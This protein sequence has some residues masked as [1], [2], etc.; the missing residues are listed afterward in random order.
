MWISFL[1]LFT[2]SPALFALHLHPS[3]SFLT[4][5]TSSLQTPLRLNPKF[6]I[7]H[8]KFS[9]RRHLDP[10]LPLLIASSFPYLVVCLAFRIPATDYLGRATTRKVQYNPIHPFYFKDGFTDEFSLTKCGFRSNSPLIF[11]R[12][13]LHFHFHLGTKGLYNSSLVSN[14]N[15]ICFVASCSLFLQVYVKDVQ[16]QRVEI[17]SV[18]LWCRCWG[19]GMNWNEKKN[20]VEMEAL[21]YFT[22]WLPKIFGM[23]GGRTFMNLAGSIYLLSLYPFHFISS[24]NISPLPRTEP[25]LQRS[26]LILFSKFTLDWWVY[27]LWWWWY[28]VVSCFELH[29]L[30]LTDLAISFSKLSLNGN[31]RY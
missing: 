8:A 3:L 30:D 7:G 25:K 1:S 27:V 11:F 22:D 20:E 13:Q 5:R 2:S 9:R 12:K 15:Q 10:L 19:N 31:Q 28:G 29:L 6:G 23:D 4:A 16:V 14:S 17:M 21:L 18:C 24:M 26:F